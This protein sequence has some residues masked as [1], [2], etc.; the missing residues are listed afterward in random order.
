[1]KKAIFFDRDGTLLV[2][3]GY[4]A[5]ASQIWPYS[6]ACEA[7]RLARARGFLLVMVTNQSGI[8]RGWLSEEDLAAV[9]ARMQEVLKQGGAE[10]DAIYYCPHHPQGTVERYRQSCSCRKPAP[11]LGLAAIRDLG[12]DAA[13]SL[14]IGDKAS[15]LRFGQALGLSTCLVRT[16]FGAAEEARL[17]EEGLS[18]VHVAGNALEAVSWAIQREAEI[19]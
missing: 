1:V 19:A 7:L 6:F 15:D 17:G 12:I 5:H 14:V 3:M 10:L 16:G 2:E 18:G 4:V 9:H 8:A 13:R 11:G